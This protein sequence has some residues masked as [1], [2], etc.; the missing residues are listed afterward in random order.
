M[1]EGQPKKSLFRNLRF[2]ILLI[3]AVLLATIA[4]PF[5]LTSRKTPGP[6]PGLRRI[7][8]I[9]LNGI[10]PTLSD[11]QK[12][13]TL[14]KAA[15]YPSSGSSFYYYIPT[16]NGSVRLQ[17]EFSDYNPMEYWRQ[18]KVSPAPQLLG[19][20]SFYELAHPSRDEDTM[21]LVYRR[22]NLTA[23][24]RHDPVHG[25]SGNRLLY[26]DQDRKEVEQVAR[27]LDE[28]LAQPSLN[29]AFQEVPSSRL[30]SDNFRNLITGL[31]WF[32]WVRVL[33]NKV[34]F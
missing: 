19:E 7:V 9:N 31:L 10:F 23:H 3:F 27:T 1:S 32:V 8:S 2:C 11:P 28:A 26:T 17:L 15:E 33:G 30:A 16:T 14:L 6:T 12:S 24:F 18:Y 25:R 34:R 13:G 20:E 29:V 5:L 22:L 4:L 21:E